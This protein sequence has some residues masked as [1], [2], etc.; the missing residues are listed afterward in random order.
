MRL[1]WL[2]PVTQNGA[3]GQFVQAILHQAKQLRLGQTAA[4][5]AFLTMLALVPLFSVGLW[6]LTLS[7]K[8]A[9]LKASFLLLVGELFLPAVSDVVLK[10]LNQFASH[11]NQLPIWAAAGFVLTAVLALNTFER[12]LNLIWG[13]TAKRSTSKRF[14]LYGVGLL[15]GPMLAGAVIALAQAIGSPLMNT[16]IAWYADSRAQRKAVGSLFNQLW[17]FLI[18]LFSLASAYRFVPSGKVHWQF[19]MLGGAVAA[20][21]IEILKWGLGAYLTSLPGLKTVYGA[22]AV[23]PILLIWLNGVWLAILFGAVLAAVLQRLP[24]LSGQGNVLPLEGLGT[25]AAQLHTMLLHLKTELQGSDQSWH[26]LKALKSIVGLG[27][28]DRAALFN[29]LLHSGA[30]EVGILPGSEPTANT[31]L[32]STALMLRWNN[33]KAVDLHALAWR[34]H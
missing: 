30:I 14:L 21:L 26:R 22:L 10:Y 33:A 17:P 23:I 8:F 6:A 20:L 11:V 34:G 12:T 3:I 5:L 15:A 31:D 18:I 19:A 25:T 9:T 29:C 28:H 2:A 16:F 27:Y 1:A 32:G 7:P 24:S 4:S 13:Y